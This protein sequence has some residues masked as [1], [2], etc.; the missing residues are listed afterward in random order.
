[1]GKNYKKSTGK[2]L[3]VLWLLVLAGVFL[4]PKSTEAA[5]TKVSPGQVKLSVGNKKTLK[6]KNTKGKVAWT[7]NKKSV[8]Q[9]SAKGV[10]TARKK[11][12]A[13]I[14]AKVSGRKYKCRVK[15]TD[16][17]LNVFQCTISVNAVKQLKFKTYSGKGVVWKSDNAGVATVTKK[18]IVKGIKPGTAV[19]SAKLQ[20]ST[21]KCRVTVSPAGEG[22][23][24]NEDFIPSRDWGSIMDF[25][26][27]QE[28]TEFNKTSAS[29]SPYLCGWLS[30]GEETK[31]T[32]YSVD[33]R[34]DYIPYGTYL[35]CANMRMDLSSLEQEYDEVYMDSW[36]SFYAG[37]QM[38]EPEKGS[39]SIMSFW[40]VYCKDKAGEISTVRAKL[41]YPEN[42]AENAFGHEGN[43]VNYINDF[44]WE[45]GH[46]YRML[47]RCGKSE[48]NG[49]TLVEQLVCDL[50]TGK[51]T[52][53]C[54]YDTGLSD[55]CFV[56]DAAVFLENYLTEYAG[57]IRTAEYKNFRIRL[58]DTGQW[59]PMK[60]ITMSDS[61]DYSGSF[62]FGADDEQFWMIT[63]GLEKRAILQCGKTGTYMV[64]SC[65]D[66]S[67]Y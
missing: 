63:T 67:P 22:E 30:L 32:E 37:L 16:A 5:K 46:W 28:I 52:K 49:H 50:E 54:C 42:R 12:N 6:V 9:V 25:P 1:M 47:L 31:F 59:I 29:R 41:V 15:V 11:G 19:I 62:C 17:K 45:R 53:I 24:D 65:E 8:A 43:G 39:A 21:Y 51:W 56:G 60:Q 10:V 14:T 44:A 34:A 33:F 66:D 4:M 64:T 61:F 57:D 55:S 40:D 27:E 58:K 20:S 23:E 13:T 38:R 48:E 36:L 26:S 3:V 7:S 18:G 35:S 2:K